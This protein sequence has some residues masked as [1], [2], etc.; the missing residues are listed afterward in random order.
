MS[1]ATRDVEQTTT[2]SSSSATSYVDREDQNQSRNSRRSTVNILVTP[3][4][5]STTDVDQVARTGKGEDFK[6]CAP[7]P[8]RRHAKASLRQL[9]AHDGTDVEIL[10]D[11]STVQVVS[12]RTSIARAC[13]SVDTGLQDRADEM[14]DSD[15][16]DSK[17]AF[18]ARQSW[19]SAKG[20]T[21]K[22]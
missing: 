20:L 4:L 18:R 3:R 7:F 9:S 17:V 2:S 15:A 12:L 11:G 16:V 10:S 21:S 13:Q 14:P 1:S 8:R 5:L 19:R 22:L 6:A